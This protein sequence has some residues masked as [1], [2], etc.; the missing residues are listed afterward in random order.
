MAP[1]LVDLSEKLQ[2]E[3]NQIREKLVENRDF[4]VPGYIA[5]NDVKVKD[6]ESFQRAELEKSQS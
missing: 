3:H 6:I 4:I 2:A 1:S 5:G